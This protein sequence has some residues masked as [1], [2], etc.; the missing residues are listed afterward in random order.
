MLANNKSGTMLS[1]KMKMIKLEKK[2]CLPLRA[3]QWP[4]MWKIQDSSVQT[5]D[6]IFPKI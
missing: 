3:V 4:H 2:Q 1:M 5:C 6:V